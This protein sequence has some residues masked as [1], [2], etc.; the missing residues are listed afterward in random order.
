[1]TFQQNSTETQVR[2]G[3]VL[4]G[5]KGR[6]ELTPEGCDHVAD[7]IK[8]GIAQGKIQQKI[9]PE[10]SYEI[11]NVNW[12]PNF[13]YNEILKHKEWVYNRTAHN[14]AFNPTFYLAKQIKKKISNK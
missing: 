13:I 11:M 3:C 2:M 8:D 6:I 10:N 5:P 7:L 4:D 14:F 9:R 12:V 1:M